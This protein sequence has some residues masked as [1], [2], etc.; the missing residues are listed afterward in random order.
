MNI[1]R[2]K[3][4]CIVDV[5]IIS[6]WVF[7]IYIILLLGPSIWSSSKDRIDA[8]FGMLFCKLISLYFLEVHS[9][10]FFPWNMIQYKMFTL[11]EQV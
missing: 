5:V 8:G 1:D 10:E 2:Q 7:Y 11:H 9:L 4:N 3:S 6:V